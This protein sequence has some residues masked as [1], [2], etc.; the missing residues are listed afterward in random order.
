MAEA[1]LKLKARAQSLRS[2]FRAIQGET[3]TLEQSLKS[4][5]ALKGVNLKVSGETQM[6]ALKKASG[7]LRNELL[8]LKRQRAIAI[9]TG[10][11]QN[12][13]Q[14]LD[15]KINFVNRDL[16]KL[17]NEMATLRPPSTL[18]R[19]STGFTNVGGAL[20]KTG[21]KLQNFSRVNQVAVGGAVKIAYDYSKG[22][23]HLG[24]VS[25]LSVAKNKQLGAS[26]T[27]TAA[28]M[29]IDPV[30]ALDAGYQG[31]SNSLIGS[32]KDMD[33]T[34]K[35]VGK[36][37][38]VT[39][40]D[41]K[42]AMS[43][44]GTIMN[45]YGKKAGSLDHVMDTLIQTEKKG[46]TTV[47]ELASAMGQVVPVA[48]SMGV[49]LEQVEA[50]LIAVT[51]SGSTTSE[52]TTKLSGIFTAFLKPGEALQG[53]IE[54][55]GISLQE[56][57][58]KGGTLPEY[59]KKLKENFHGTNSEFAAMFGNK[60]AISG[61]TTLMQNDFGNVNQAM[62]DLKD[63]TG[64]TNEEFKKWQNTDVA[65]MEEG[66]AKLKLAGV[67]LGLKIL[68]VV[69]GIVDWLSKLSPQTVQVL[70]GA[71][72]ASAVASPI[73]R[74]LGSAFSLVGGAINV[75]KT[76][77]AGGSFMTAIGS[78]ITGSVPAIESSVA[79]V[80]TTMV[81]GGTSWGKML[82][83]GLAGALG[84][85]ALGFATGKIMEWSGSQVSESQKTGM[86]MGG[87]IGGGAGAVIGSAMG[88]VGTI[89]GG[90]LGASLGTAVGYAFGE[91]YEKE[92]QKAA[93]KMEEGWK[94]ATLSTAQAMKG[95][96]TEAFKGESN[97]ISA[98]ISA[99]STQWSKS[100]ASFATNA[101]RDAS[102]IKWNFTN[103][104]GESAN[105]FDGWV[106]VAAGSSKEVRNNM[107]SAMSRA[108]GVSEQK[109]NNLINK[110]K[111]TGKVP[112]HPDVKIDNKNALSAL[113]DVINK[114]GATNAEDAK[115][116]VEIDNSNAINSLQNVIDS[117]HAV[118]GKTVFV[119]IVNRHYAQA[120]RNMASGMMG[121]AIGGTVNEGQTYK[122][123]EGHRQE[124]FKNRFGKIAPIIGNV[125][126]PGEKGKV[127]TNGQS[128]KYK[129]DVT[130]T[131]PNTTIVKPII[132]IYDASDPHKVGKILENKLNNLLH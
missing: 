34:I 110:L 11:S 18:T 103:A 113:Q 41:L 118:R 67:D 96:L 76:I 119:D 36:L 28:A 14:K 89:V 74:G 27:K 81:S 43:V 86:D 12:E 88:P 25:G 92:Q 108:T 130:T 126:T 22:V 77:S 60:N 44:S 71:I 1:T 94:K 29:G 47:P 4:L 124:M 16:H 69:S 24:V 61:V 132:N 45:V 66:F 35:S 82:G 84:G 23:Q 98:D 64:L 6:L 15:N 50:S 38:K 58:K 101:G 107:V 62:K 73:L 97:V 75:F 93:T 121:R 123:N 80:G 65:K 37:S 87:A 111:E 59:M 49:G 117:I 19:I 85:G 55:T 79:N 72:V 9:K 70:T 122:V 116:H 120:Q 56:F 54:K 3:K 109:L 95:T 39:G 63:S 105:A 2:E 53:V 99:K 52:A 128:K 10:A 5:K 125:F 20:T 78:A 21:Q 8:N 57:E 83:T 91:T 31:L 104:M 129:D 26:L 127:L 46:V 7:S 42:D 48:G 68:P 51:K 115:P 100:L 102:E 90:V 13:I 112:A 131:T 40:T 30:E 33:S 114:L 32:T 17:N 106:G